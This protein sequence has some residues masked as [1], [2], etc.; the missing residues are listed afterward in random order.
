MRL[1][2]A[3]ARHDGRPGRGR[4]PLRRRGAGRH[5]ARPLR[6]PRR[7]RDAGRAGAGRR[8]PPRRVV[9]RAAGSCRPSSSAPGH[10]R[11]RWPRW[12]RPGSCRRAAAPSWS[13]RRPLPTPRA[14][15]V[16]RHRRRGRWTSATAAEARDVMAGD[17]RGPHDLRRVHGRR[18]R[19]RGHRPAAGPPRRPGGGVRL[20]HRGGR[21]RPGS[22]P[23][24]PSPAPGAEGSRRPSSRTGSTWPARRAATWSAPP[25]RS[26][27]TAPATCSGSGSGSCRTSGCWNSALAGRGVQDAGQAGT[28][29]RRDE[30]DP[31]LGGGEGTRTPNPLLAKQVRYQLRHAPGGRPGQ[32]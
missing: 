13:G 20:G 22:A 17:D 8:R 31:G 21:A 25:P 28:P 18:P 19:R 23:P 12:P 10:R 1:A 15:A 9:R 5:R 6:E 27:P 32:R 7:G 2:A 3:L 26:G 14:P 24:A 29:S 4:R 30:R 11:G 16:H